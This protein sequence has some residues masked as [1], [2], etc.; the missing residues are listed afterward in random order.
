MTSTISTS[1]SAGRL[2]VVDLTSTSR[3]W[4]L[5]E[6]GEAHLRAAAPPGWRTYFVSAA[7]ISDGDGSPTPS[8]EALAAITEAEVYF[9]FGIS[10]PL[11]AAGRRLRWVHSATA[12]MGSLLFPEMVA[13]DVLLTNSAGVHGPPIAESV[14]AGVL[15]FLRGL[16]VAVDQ[17]RAGTW[18]KAFFVS[19]ESPLREVADCRV[20]VIGAGGIGSEVAT[21]FNA[22]GA[23]CVGVRRRPARGVPPGF[24]RVAGPDAIDAELPQADVVVVAA[25]FTGET[26]GLLDARRLDL[27]PANAIV[28]NVARGALVDEAALATRLAEGRLRGAVLDVFGEEPLAPSSPLWQLRSALLTPHVSAVSPL[29]FWPRQLALFVDNWNRYVRGEP[30]RNLVDKHAGY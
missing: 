6:G 28:V 13:S 8:A 7:T 26:S 16:D 15:H 19:G 22:L 21:R 4:A 29:R 9:G 25:P 1:D 10:R 18:R 24:S 11:F 20:L 23:T 27:L 14:L 17:Q 5:R 30:L 12:G 2:V 3:N